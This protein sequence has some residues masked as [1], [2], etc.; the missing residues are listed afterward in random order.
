[1]QLVKIHNLGDLEVLNRYTN[2]GPISDFCVINKP[3]GL[4]KIIM[5]SGTHEKSFLEVFNTGTGII[6]E[7]CLLEIIKI[8]INSSPH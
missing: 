2:S 8:S 3:G 6:V 4:H 5:C 1:M 7:V